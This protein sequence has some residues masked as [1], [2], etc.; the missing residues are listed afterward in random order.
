MHRLSVKMNHLPSLSPSLNPSRSALTLTTNSH[1]MKWLKKIFGASQATPNKEPTIDDNILTAEQ[2]Y[3]LTL[4]WV[5]LN[6]IIAGSQP[7]PPRGYNYSVPVSVETAQWAKPI[8]LKIETADRFANRGA[9]DYAITGYQEALS[10]APGCAVAA[11]SIAACF[12]CQG[13][14]EL[15]RRN[16]QRA[17][18]FD[19]NNQRVKENAKE[20]GL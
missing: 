8:V 4:S 19:P 14:R 10:L 17:L 11:M 12:H 13:E 9:F 18:R 2:Q 6:H 20:I 15:A 7:D 5:D 1:R 16:M 3:A